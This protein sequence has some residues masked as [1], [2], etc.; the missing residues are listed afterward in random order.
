MSFQEVR[1]LS[2]VADAPGGDTF[3][4]QMTS[5]SQSVLSDHKFKFCMLC[6]CMQKPQG[7]KRWQMAL[8]SSTSTRYTMMFTTNIDAK[9]IADT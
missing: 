9:T 2:V 3:E 6:R 8:T 5:Y 4:V 1:R 7:K